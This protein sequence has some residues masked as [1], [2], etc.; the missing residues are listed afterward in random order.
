MYCIYRQSTNNILC[1]DE[2]FHNILF[3]TDIPNFNIKIWKSEKAANK[4]AT[5]YN[6]TVISFWRVKVIEVS[7]IQSLPKKCAE[8]CNHK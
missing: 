1:T 5:S 7:A 3:V 8:V 6:E 2:E 4:Y